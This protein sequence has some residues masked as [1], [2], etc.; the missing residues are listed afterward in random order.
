[1]LRKCYLGYGRDIHPNF[2]NPTVNNMFNTKVVACDWITTFNDA[3]LIINKKRLKNG[4]NYELYKDEYRLMENMTMKDGT[5]PIRVNKYTAIPDDY[6][7]WIFSSIGALDAI[8]FDEFEWYLTNAAGFYNKT[9]PM[10]NP[11]NHNTFD[12]MV[13]AQTY[14]DFTG[15]SQKER[16]IACKEINEIGFHGIVLRRR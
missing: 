12:E 11:F 4:F 1:M 9:N 8:S 3:Q 13:M 10:F 16:R 5:H 6:K 14:I 15:M 2:I 7:G